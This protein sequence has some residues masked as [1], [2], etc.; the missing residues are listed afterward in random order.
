MP[1]LVEGKKKAAQMLEGQ[2][3]AG[4]KTFNILDSASPTLAPS[5]QASRTGQAVQFRV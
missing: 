4:Y 2:A 5:H 3:A 1:R